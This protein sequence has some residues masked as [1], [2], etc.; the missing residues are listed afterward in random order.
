MQNTRLTITILLGAGIVLIVVIGLFV[1]SFV[2][3][4]QQD[5]LDTQQPI[6]RT[7]EGEN[8]KIVPTTNTQ[9]GESGP[10]DFRDDAIE[11]Q[12]REFPDIFLYNN[13]P[14]ENQYFRVIGV[15]RAEG[16]PDFSFIVTL[17]GPDTTTSQT[18]FNEWLIELGLSP[19]Q[20]AALL[21]EYR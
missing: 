13:V 7:I 5:S 1:V 12:K 6:D 20:A 9:Q 15:G 16:N 2:R 19:S 18:K 21:V 8:L 4:S 14:F 11:E 3:T 17:K 10:V